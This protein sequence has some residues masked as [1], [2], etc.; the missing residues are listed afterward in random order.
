MLIV[1]MAPMF[2]MPL[3][4]RPGDIIVVFAG[5]FILCALGSL[6]GVR[7]ILSIDPMVA[8]GR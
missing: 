3:L 8:M 7:R 4:L 1:L 2:P 5:A 6:L